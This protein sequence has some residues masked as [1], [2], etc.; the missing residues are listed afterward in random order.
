MRLEF[1]TVTFNGNLYTYIL[2]VLFP[3]FI[4]AMA[5]TIF[6]VKTQTKNMLIADLDANV[7]YNDCMRINNLIFFVIFL[8]EK[9]F[10]YIVKLDKRGKLSKFVIDTCIR[11]ILDY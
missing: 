4:L 6:A 11:N 7:P 8:S 1:S 10:V 3:T 2:R 9:P 5:I